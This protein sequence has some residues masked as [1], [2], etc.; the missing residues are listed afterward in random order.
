M[1]HSFF[2][3]SRNLTTILLADNKLTRIGSLFNNILNLQVIDI[4]FNHLKNID[5]E[6]F[7]GMSKLKILKLNDNKL[8]HL[9]LKLFDGIYELN[10]LTLSNNQFKEGKKRLSIKLTLAD[11]DSKAYIIPAS[12]DT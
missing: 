7:K 2:K 10:E 12:V 5:I 4:A 3:E 9:S 8:R 6:A 11:C 1:D